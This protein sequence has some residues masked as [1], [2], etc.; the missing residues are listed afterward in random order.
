VPVLDVPVTRSP[1][2]CEGADAS[3]DV[4]LPEVSEDEP[5]LPDALMP[6]DPELPEV[7]SLAPDEPEAL[8]PLDPEA[9]EL[10]SP[11]PDAPEDDMPLLPEESD[12]PD[13]LLPEGMEPD[14][15]L[16]PDMPVSLPVVAPI[17]L[18]ERVEEE[19]SLPLPIVAPLCARAMEDTD[20]TTT[21]DRVRRVVLM[22]MSNSFR[23]KK[24]HRRCCILDA[25]CMGAFSQRRLP[26]AARSLIFY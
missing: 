16:E 12:M 5:P 10:A 25:A 18:C 23:L 6:P 17:G 24:E 19:G 8:E 7:V 4:L 22:I 15:P 2:A 20:A 21:N 1:G 14:A 26:R 3:L 13:E 9:P 11:A